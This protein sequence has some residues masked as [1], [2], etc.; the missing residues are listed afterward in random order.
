MLFLPTKCNDIIH[1]VALLAQLA[2]PLCEL[3]MHVELARHHLTASYILC[4]FQTHGFV[5]V[6]QA[7]GQHHSQIR[8]HTM[9]LMM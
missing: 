1:V 7:R 5:Q 3:H 9:F 2:T 6:L 8:T 4:K